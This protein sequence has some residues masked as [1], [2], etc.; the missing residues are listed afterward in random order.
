MPSWSQVSLPL[1]SPSSGGGAKEGEGAQAQAAVLSKKMCFFQGMSVVIQEHCVSKDGDGGGDGDSDAGF[2]LGS[3]R[4]PCLKSSS[5]FRAYMFVRHTDMDQTPLR[6]FEKLRKSF[7]RSMVIPEDGEDAGWMEGRK[8]VTWLTPC[9]GTVVKRMRMVRCVPGTSDS[10]TLKVPMGPG[11][12]HWRLALWTW[13]PQS[14]RTAQV[15]LLQP[16]A[17]RIVI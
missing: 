8:M 10:C 6:L 7:Q 2:L 13:R 1:L 3:K 9:F 5:Y 17:S 16:G 14:V 4:R 12:Q 15:L 11:P